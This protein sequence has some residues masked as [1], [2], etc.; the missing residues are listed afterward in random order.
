MKSVR[1]ENPEEAL[2]TLHLAA[3]AAN[4]GI[5]DFD[6]Q[7]AELHWSERCRAIFGM[8]Q[9]GLVTL[10]TFLERLHPEERDR[11]QATIASSLD[12][13]GTHEYD[14]EYR[15]CRP[16]HELRY[17]Q[18][19][20][21]AFFREMNGHLQ[22]TRFVGTV[23]DRT[24]QKLA[25]AALVQAE[26]LATTGR[27]AASIAHEI[28]NPLEAVT[29]LLYL[30]RDEVHTNAGT[31]YLKQAET[32]LARVTEIATNTLRF[33]R[34]PKE[35]VKVNVSGLLHSVLTLFHGRLAVH[36]VK[37]DFDCSS[38][39]HVFTQQGQ[40]R[41][42]LVNLIGNAIDAM[43]K[44]GWLR[45]RCRTCHLKFPGPQL[46]VRVTI[47]DTGVGMDA[48]MLQRAF[49]PFYTTK[50]SAGTGLGLWLSREIIYKQKYA[51][52]VKSKP[53][54][55]TAFSLCI[56]QRTEPGSETIA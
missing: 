47:A 22:A 21:K 44:G 6:V 39:L 32:E 34:D 33:Q 26:Q 45:V 3:E 50:G 11:V 46:G 28:N 20:G 49:E 7:T 51:L 14:I 43:N 23:L 38:S 40:L 17:V 8:P 27:L 35:P 10:D 54:H 41:Q 1:F 5:W 19:K 31:E 52:K 30:L 2:A 4:L 29:N 36:G 18:A 24:D 16:N 15:I 48:E 9:P 42:V 12:P 25:Q 13:N 56:P 53:G 55:G 37:V